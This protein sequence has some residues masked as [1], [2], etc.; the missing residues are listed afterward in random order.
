MTCNACHEP[1][2]SRICRHLQAHAIQ[3]SN[4]GMQDDAFSSANNHLHRAWPPLHIS[5][6]SATCLRHCGQKWCVSRPSGSSKPS[7]HVIIAH[8]LCAHPRVCL[9]AQG[10]ASAAADNSRPSSVPRHLP[11]RALPC[12]A[13]AHAAVTT[14]HAL[15]AA[16]CQAWGQS[17][18]KIVKQAHVVCEGP[19]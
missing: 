6:A 4:Q 11:A 19:W 15:H 12:H 3:N 16:C 17:K 5:L 18:G 14:L 2:G 8:M 9:H 13:M 7:P 10:T 1:S